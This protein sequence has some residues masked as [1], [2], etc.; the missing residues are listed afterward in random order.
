M[1]NANPNQAI[2]KTWLQI[3]GKAEVCQVAYISYIDYKT[4]N[5]WH[6]AEQ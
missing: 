3:G 1:L 2:D 4:H 5:L 6:H